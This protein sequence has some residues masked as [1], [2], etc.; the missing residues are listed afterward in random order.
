[1]KDAI[2]RYNPTPDK[3]FKEIYSIMSLIDT[4]RHVV[5]VKPHPA[6][7][8][9]IA[10]GTILTILLLL[11]WDALGIAALIITLFI[12]YFFRDPVRVVP[13]REGLIVAPADGRI[14]SIKSDQSL[15]DELSEEDDSETYTKISIFLS[16]LDV[17]VNRIPVAGEIVKTFYYEG[18]FLNAE[19]DKASE[20]NERASAL[21]KTP[22]NKFVGVCQIA[23][24]I[25]R[26]IITDLEEGKKVETGEKYGIIRFG[27]RT[28]IYLPK[29]VN[30]LVSVGQ[31]AIGGETILAD[32]TSKEESRTGKY[33]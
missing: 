1:M 29:G 24:L 11:I 19:L 27:S 28:D 12:L 22:N 15:P 4:I 23:G 20:E 2:K 6:G 13:Q 5:L 10:G 8:P 14:I 7:W 32:M 21:I 25:A 17:H 16:V 18:K 9:F 3:K 26:R 33:L 31:R 30:P